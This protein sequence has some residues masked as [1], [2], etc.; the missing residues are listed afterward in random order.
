ME[1]LLDDKWSRL[2]YVECLNAAG[3]TVPNNDIAAISTT[4][5]L[6]SPSDK[7]GN[8]RP[9]PINKNL[10]FVVREKLLIFLLAVKGI[11]GKFY[12]EFGFV[13]QYLYIKVHFT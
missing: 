4:V 1:Q 11:S 10:K 9:L 12:P 2:W 6:R 8:I 13:L 5:L 7:R 3:A